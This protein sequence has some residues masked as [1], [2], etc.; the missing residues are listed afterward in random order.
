MEDFWG[1]S[2]VGQ[3]TTDAQIAYTDKLVVENVTRGASR[4]WSSI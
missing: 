2:G 3:W 4:L 1:Q